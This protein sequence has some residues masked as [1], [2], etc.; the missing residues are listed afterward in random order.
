MDRTQP[1]A[2]HFV[3]RPERQTTVWKPLVHG[4]DP[5]RQG[6][7][8]GPLRALDLA[9]AS[10]QFRDEMGLPK[11]RHD[12]LLDCMLPICSHDR[13]AEGQQVKRAA[14]APIKWERLMTQI[15]Q[16]LPLHLKTR[17]ETGMLPRGWL[18]D[19]K[20]RYEEFG[21]EGFIALDREHT[22]DLS[23]PFVLG[24]GRDRQEAR[25]TASGRSNK[26]PVTFVIHPCTAALREAVASKPTQCFVFD[27]VA[28]LQGEPTPI[29]ALEDWLDLGT[30]AAHGDAGC[31]GGH[32]WDE[33]ICNIT[34]V[35]YAYLHGHEAVAICDDGRLGWTAAASLRGEVEADGIAPLSSDVDVANKEIEAN[36]HQKRRLM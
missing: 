27:D 4:P 26:D 35:A 28:Y 18:K 3:Q 6:V 9:H 16:P 5:K 10:P 19:L 25:L 12:D 29:E 15:A 30:Y 14:N 24:W 34:E 2:G 36:L 8:P 7:G 21:P 33:M 31:T 23:A 13:A 20:Q 22:K 17:P 1:S 32:G 11:D